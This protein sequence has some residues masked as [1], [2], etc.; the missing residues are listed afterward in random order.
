MRRALFVIC[1]LSLAGCASEPNWQRADLQDKE[2]RQKQLLI[3]KGECTRVSIGAAPTPE[4]VLPSQQTQNIAIQGNTYN[5]STGVWSH[6]TYSGQ[7]TDGA[8]GGFY[9]GISNGFGN[10]VALGATLN[11]EI[12]QE[13]IFNGC[14][15][16]KGWTNAPEGSQLPSPSANKNAAA[17]TTT[18]S[19]AIEWQRD[20]DEFLWLYPGYRQNDFY[21][22]LDAKVRTIAKEQ[23][24]L[25]GKQILLAARDK[26]KNEGIEVSS[27]NTPDHKLAA[28]FIELR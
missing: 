3:D 5:T 22:K 13:T 17:A 10:G 6:S 8:S 1:T 7:I 20:V 4:I 19:A 18:N 9:G 23:P 16:A 24:T 26:L 12:Q 2:A 25:S 11:A 21:Q 14:M 15:T 27:P 28:T